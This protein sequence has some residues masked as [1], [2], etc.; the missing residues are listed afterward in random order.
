MKILLANPR[1]FCAGVDR[2][3]EIVEEALRLY[4]APIYVL[5]EIVHN[6]H[7]LRGLRERG[8]RFVDELSEIPAGGVTIFSA[9]G[10]AEEVER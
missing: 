7:V 5:Q 10:V 6:K 8:V 2:A 9:H 3:I 1:G 4:G